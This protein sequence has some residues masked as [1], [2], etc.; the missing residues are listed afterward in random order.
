M[1]TK[2]Q[3]NIDQITEFVKKFDIKLKTEISDKG[4]LTI[5]QTLDSKSIVIKKDEIKDL[6]QRNDSNGQFFMQ[7]NFENGKRI[8]LTDLLIGFEPYPI[9]GLEP[10]MLPKVVTTQDLHNVFEALENVVS[11]ETTPKNEISALKK[12][13]DSIIQGGEAIGF[14]LK[15]EKCWPHGLAYTK[16]SA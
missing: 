15:S 16:A 14:N 8:L 3:N 13:F 4:N 1:D 11:D 6:L 9:E 2:Q 12:I 10:N 7:V 5:T